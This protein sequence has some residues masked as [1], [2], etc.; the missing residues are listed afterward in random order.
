MPLSE[1]CA[2]AV[3]SS[4]IRSLIDHHISFVIRGWGAYSKILMCCLAAVPLQWSP[5]VF[6]CI[7]SRIF[8]DFLVFFNTYFGYENKLPL[9]T[10]NLSLYLF[11][12]L[13]MRI[14]AC[15]WLRAVC[16]CVR[17]YIAVLHLHKFGT[18]FILQYFLQSGYRTE[19]ACTVRFGTLYSLFCEQDLPAVQI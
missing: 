4:K 19:W 18:T 17:N 9:L 15:T 2:N 5:C 10:I 14:C 3:K 8:C 13:C 6:R 12:R 11:E 16:V 1:I 7:C